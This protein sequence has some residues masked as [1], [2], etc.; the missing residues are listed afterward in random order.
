MDA[1]MDDKQG[2]FTVKFF[3]ILAFSFF[4]FHDTPSH[5]TP[6]SRSVSSLPFCTVTGFCEISP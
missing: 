3:L 5:D 6:P 2:Q 1:L 4:A